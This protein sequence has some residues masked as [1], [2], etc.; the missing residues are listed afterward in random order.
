V[1]IRLI[2]PTTVPQDVSHLGPRLRLIRDT[3]S[4]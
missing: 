4:G 3:G 2:C 1:Q